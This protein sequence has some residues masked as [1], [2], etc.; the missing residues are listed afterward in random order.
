M[1][2]SASFAATTSDEALAAMSAE[3]LDVLVIGGG[4]VGAG[5]ALDAVTRGLS[6][7]IVEA[8][9][10]ASGT[11]SRSSK[12]IHGGLR[13]LEMLDF[14]LVREALRERG[15]LLNKLA[16]H[17]VRPVPFL[18][19]LRH[20]WERLYVGAGVTLYDTLGLT[21]RSTRGVPWHRQLSR[22]TALQVCPALRP[23]ALTGAV[24]YYDAQVDDARL[25]MLL[26]RTAVGFGARAASRASVVELLRKDGRVVGAEVADLE[27]DRRHTIR[28]RRVINA[29]GVWSDETQEL[30][31]EEAIVHISPSKGV[32][33]VVARDRIDS[34]SGLILRTATSVLFVIPWG[35]HWII[36]TTDTPWSLDKAHP[37]ASRRDL[38]YL[39]DQVNSVLAQPLSHEDIQAVY[40]GL[41]PLL[42]GGSE[43][44]AKLSREHIVAS[45]VPG[46]I[47]VAGGKYTTYRVMAQDAVDAAAADLD[48]TVPPSCTVDTPLLG[49]AGFTALW[50]RRYALAR[51]MALRTEQVEHLLHRYG[52]LVDE[53]L[54]LIR[55]DPG[56]GEPLPGAGG[57]LRA[58]VAYAVTHEDARHLDDVLERRTHIAIETTNHGVAAAPAVAS[59]MAPLLG[60][61]PAQAEREVHDYELTVAAQQAAQ[62]QPDDDAAVAAGSGGDTTVPLPH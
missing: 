58:E 53:L 16:P 21:S 2:L 8:D 24:R 35:E 26:V 50:N 41:R 17:L 10:W 40:A 30:T 43:L 15:L 37:T 60:W 42:S 14:R 56:L 6:V 44:T 4:V 62:Q 25:V 5:C 48:Q 54:T 11:S 51:Q 38:D 3:P 34:S 29:T 27:N 12:L 28:A 36:G 19:P 52:S 57:Y 49:A 33:L 47:V 18:Y 59:I 20:G 13:Y 9:D 22:G 55:E 31:G 7:G 61:T 39:L 46:L 45:P 32:H 1:A 23:G